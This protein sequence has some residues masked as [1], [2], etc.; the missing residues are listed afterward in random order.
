M[1]CS[2]ARFKLPT[3][4][5]FGDFLEL[6]H[7]ALGF[8]LFAEELW[9]DIWSVPAE[10]VCF[11]WLQARADF[12]GAAAF[13]A[14]PSSAGKARGT[15]VSGSA[16]ILRVSGSSSADQ[17]EPRARFGES[18]S[19]CGKL[20]GEMSR[21]SWRPGGFISSLE[22]SR[23]MRESFAAR[24]AADCCEITESLLDLAIWRSVRSFREGFP[25][26]T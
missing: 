8:T 26:M 17:F 9:A 21:S 4:L 12:V 6:P 7:L 24:F 22:D 18:P 2:G 15:L 5:A 3:L 16:E 13:G 20:A 19:G 11:V 14:R 10:M 1:C 25:S 23:G